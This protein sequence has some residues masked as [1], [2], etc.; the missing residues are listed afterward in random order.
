MSDKPAVEV[1]AVEVKA[2]RLARALETMILAGGMCANSC[3]NL[4]QDKVL[5]D[6]TRKSLRE[7]SDRWDAALP[8]LRELLI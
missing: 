3:F 1:L 4:S 6:Q 7:A 5:D 8:A 2:I